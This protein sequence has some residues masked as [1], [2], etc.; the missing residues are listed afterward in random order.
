MPTESFGFHINSRLSKGDTFGMGKDA[1]TLN[2]PKIRKETE[3][4]RLLEK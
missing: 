2:C 4:L 1:S 3:G